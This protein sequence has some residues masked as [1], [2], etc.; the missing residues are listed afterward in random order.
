MRTLASHVRSSAHVSMPRPNSKHWPVDGHAVHHLLRSR[1]QGTTYA[2]R[3][4][5]SQL[6]HLNVLLANPSG[7]TTM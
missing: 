4:F 6:L 7:V 2:I 3:A 5:R 1:E